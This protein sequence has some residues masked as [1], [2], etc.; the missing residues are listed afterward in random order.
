MGIGM[1]DQRLE[2]IFSS[3]IPELSVFNAHSH[4]HYLLRKEFFLKDTE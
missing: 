1:I 3:L 4:Q 2:S